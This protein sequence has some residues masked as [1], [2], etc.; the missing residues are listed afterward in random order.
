MS[1]RN[2]RPFL[3]AGRAA[4]LVL[5]AALATVLLSGCGEDGS[6]GGKSADGGDSDMVASIAEIAS[7]DSF[8]SAASGFLGY[9]VEITGTGRV[10]KYFVREQVEIGNGSF[11]MDVMFETIQVGEEDLERIG[12][13][14]SDAGLTLEAAPVGWSYAGSAPGE[15]HYVLASQE[16]TALHCKASTRPGGGSEGVTPPAIG[17]TALLVFCDQVRDLAVEE[18]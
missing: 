7:C 8:T 9:P 5:G 14:V 18:E 12:D 3:R 13:V 2:A 16:G 6:T 4:A 17:P 10:C 1:H 15:L 11:W